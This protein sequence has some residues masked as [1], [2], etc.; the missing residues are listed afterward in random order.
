MSV[1]DWSGTLIDWKSALIE[2]KEHIAPTLGR[3]E[4]RFSAGAFIDG[5]LSATERKTGWML[6]EDAGFGRPYRIQ[7]ILGRSSWS[8]DHLR[9]LVRGYA[10]ETL[11]C[12]D[13]VLVIDETGF[14]KKGNHS[15]GV[16]RQY[17][18]TVGRVENSQI[19]VFAR[20]ASRFDHALIDRQLYLPKAWGT[21]EVRRKRR[22][23]QAMS[24]SP[25]RRRWRVT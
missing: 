18:G 3:A 14:L 25:P 24:P 11:G 21:D 17:S 22:M 2:V 6:A 7:S 20:Y 19:G 12:T 9:V 10:I 15:V 5:M 23:F 1:A 16:A 8:A 4:T 13:G